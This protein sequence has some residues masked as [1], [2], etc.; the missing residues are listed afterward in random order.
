[1]VQQRGWSHFEVHNFTMK[2]LL[3]LRYLRVWT[4]NVIQIL[5]QARQRGP[6]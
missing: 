6:A 5:F 3:P 1:M 2:L 4:Y